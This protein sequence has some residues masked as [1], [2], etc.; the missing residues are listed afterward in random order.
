MENVQSG[1]KTWENVISVSVSSNQGIIG[2]LSG[3]R[4]QFLIVASWKRH[5]RQRSRKWHIRALLKLTLPLVYLENI[6]I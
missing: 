5:L 6:G 2:V 3:L 1:G 4:K